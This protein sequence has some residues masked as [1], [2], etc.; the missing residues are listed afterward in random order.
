MPEGP[1]VTVL[2]I[3]LNQIAQ[4]K[5]LKQIDVLKGGK[6]ENKA[7]NNYNIFCK[8]LPTKVDYIK[9]K[10]KLMYWAFSNGSMM[11]NHLNMTG[12]WSINKKYKHSALKFI[13]EDGLILYYTDVRRFGRVEFADSYKDIKPILDKLGIDVVND[14]NFSF[15]I[16]EKLSDK[17]KKCNITKFL[18]DQHI[19]SGIGN[20]MKSEILYAA[21]I[22]PH[23]TIGDLSVEEKKKVFRAIKQVS[24]ESVKYNGMSMSDFKDLDGTEGDY[25]SF[26]K[27]Y[28]RET[29]PLGNKVI[30][31][32]TKDGRTT[33]WVP[34][35]QNKKLKN[36]KIRD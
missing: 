9:N 24:T 6:Y 27:V 33:H 2:T 21:K 14:P 10:G 12:V 20:Y 1:E 19:M 7:P 25:E 32:K 18:M 17:K 15:K 28:C 29:D 35:I 23:R 31:I 3:S 13:F 4:G 34:Q 5:N 26:L 22:S 30:R 16:F 11:I 8:S 36:K